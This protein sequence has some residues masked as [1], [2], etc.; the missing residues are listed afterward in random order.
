MSR[1]TSESMLAIV[2]R[3]SD[4]LQHPPKNKDYVRESTIEAHLVKQIKSLG[5]VAYKFTS[6]QRRSVPDRL[7][8][9]PKGVSFFVEC[10][11]PGAKPTPGQEREI[12]QLRAKGHTVFIIDTKDLNEIH[13]YLA[14]IGFTSELEQQ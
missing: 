9:L 7:C 13:S 3:I 4:A 8:V 11:A 6:P 10:K 12:A 1:S 5:G 2:D 14:R